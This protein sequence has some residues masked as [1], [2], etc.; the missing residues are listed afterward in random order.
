MPMAARGEV[1]RVT[2]DSVSTPGDQMRRAGL[3]ELTAPGAEV[4]L[5]RLRRRDR[6]NRPFGSATGLGALPPGDQVLEGIL[7]VRA[8]GTPFV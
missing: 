4:F 8:R 3:H 1:R 6:L 5:L 2:E 7:R